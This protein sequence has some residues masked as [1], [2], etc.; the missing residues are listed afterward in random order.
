[1][2]ETRSAS[3]GRIDAVSKSS[4]AREVA[5]DRGQQS[6]FGDSRKDDERRSVRK[7][8][9]TPKQRRQLRSKRSRRDTPR[10]VGPSRARASQAESHIRHKTSMDGARRPRRAFFRTHNDVEVF[11]TS[12]IRRMHRAGRSDEPRAEAARHGRGASSQTDKPASPHHAE[13]TSPPPRPRRLALARGFVRR[14]HARCART[15]NRRPTRGRRSVRTAL[16]RVARK[17]NFFAA[18][19]FAGAFLAA[20][21]LAAGFLAAALGAA[22]FAAALGAAA[23]FT[24]FLAVAMMCLL[25]GFGSGSDTGRRPGERPAGHRAYCAA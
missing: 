25:F 12:R 4:G 11:S 3:R 14:R 22:F 18:A 20:G 17:N 9:P 7:R 24:V 10:A 13:R 21:F 2:R 16:K 23:F 5:P 15:K 8:T 1:M 6:R 19:F